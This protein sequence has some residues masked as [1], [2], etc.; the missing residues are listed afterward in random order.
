V[1]DHVLARWQ[2]A[3]ASLPHESRQGLAG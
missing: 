2:I 1:F 3:E